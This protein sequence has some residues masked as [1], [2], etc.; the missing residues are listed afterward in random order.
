MEA[1]VALAAFRGD[2]GEG[3]DSNIFIVK[4]D[5]NADGMKST[6]LSFLAPHCH[7]SLTLRM[8]VVADSSFFA[9]CADSA[10]CWN[11]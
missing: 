5:E 4:V 8:T 7:S 11:Q 1:V 9:R 2:G 10:I 3:I 6:Y